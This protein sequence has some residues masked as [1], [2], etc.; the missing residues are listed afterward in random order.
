MQIARTRL[1]NFKDGTLATIVYK[2]VRTVL[3]PTVEHRLVTLL[4][5]AE[6][7]N[8]VLFHPDQK[9]LEREPRIIEGR[10]EVRQ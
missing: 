10:D 6:A 4:I 2:K 8:K 9:M 1:V 3:A 5:V 7:D